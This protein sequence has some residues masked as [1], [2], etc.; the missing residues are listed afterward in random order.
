MKTERLLTVIVA[1]SLTYQYQKVGI[2]CK[3]Y[4]KVVYAILTCKVGIGDDKNSLRALEIRFSV[5]LRKYIV[6]L[7]SKSRHLCIHNPL[8]I[9][10]PRRTSEIILIFH[11]LITIIM[12]RYLQYA[13]TTH[14]KVCE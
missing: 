1:R 10:A 12:C 8:V 13:D 3:D 14:K 6:L 2:R 9:I 5:R 7:L 4:I 11:K